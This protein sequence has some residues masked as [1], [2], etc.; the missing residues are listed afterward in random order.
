MVYAFRGCIFLCLS[1]GTVWLASNKLPRNRGVLHYLLCSPTF[2][3]IRQEGEESQCRVSPKTSGSLPGRWHPQGGRW[4]APITRGAACFLGE[5]LAILPHP[6]AITADSSPGSRTCSSG[7]WWKPWKDPFPPY[8]P[9][10]LLPASLTNPQPGRRLLRAW[11][12][13]RCSVF[14]MTWVISVS[15]LQESLLGQERALL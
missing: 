1:F 7:S 13:K 2:C 11:V 8:T 3:E 15:K 5:S 14:R 4:F 9:H 10:D 6:E 12:L